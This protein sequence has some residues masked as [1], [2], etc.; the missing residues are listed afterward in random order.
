MP[1]AAATLSTPSTRP[2]ATAVDLRFDTSHL[3]PDLKRRTIRGGAV[4]LSSQ[5]A[6]FLLRMGSTAVLARLLTPADFGLIAMVTVVTGFV[7]LFKDA[8]LSTAT[9]Q[10]DSV[11]HA[12]VSTLFWI[13]G[14]LGLLLMGAV[15]ALAPVIAWLYA[16]PRLT[17]VTIALAGT[18]VFGGLSVQHL[19][20]IKRRMQ[21]GRLA[22][23][24]VASLAA[25][26]I[27]AITVAINGG[28]YW[29][30]VAMTAVTAAT[31]AALSFGL[32]GWWPGLPRRGSGV[33]PMLAFG[34]NLAGAGT[35]NYLTRNADNVVV[36][37]VHGA[38]S[39]GVYSRGY[40]LF[41]MPL[42][43]FL[44]PISSVAVPALSRVVGSPED[45][46]DLLLQKSYFVAF[47]V[48]LATGYSFCAAPELVAIV[49]GPG[50]EQAAIIVRCLAIGG[51]VYGTNVAGSWVCTTHGWTNRQ[52]RVA[53]VAGPVYAV[54]Y[55]AG[56]LCGPIGVA[57][58][59]S[60]TC[61]VLRY[62]VFRY[63]LAD[64]PIRPADLIVPLLRIG[65]VAGTAAMAAIAVTA[66]LELQGALSLA[67]KTAM[68]GA[69]IAGA[70]LTGLLAIPGF[71]QRGFCN[72]A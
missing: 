72:D 20:V 61:C 6:R 2:T 69:T 1:D 63:L 14:A 33:R 27:A 62:P 38:T 9:V 71:D 67:I 31:T 22:L 24:D 66:A 64:S 19:A 26:V 70:A 44:S 59:F 17:M 16:E 55:L 30:L 42:S 10:R 43:Q 34:G 53:V 52:L 4:A 12:Q 65:A 50:W 45:F 48:T 23:I 25:G 68:Y 11:T 3:T 47:C 8:G 54:G 56:S 18:L 57:C 40:N 49:L 13:N 32:S 21:F 39:L 35:F 28:G 46:K 29:S 51:A 5:A 15:A 60:I 36:G 58:A 41:L 7:E 37:L